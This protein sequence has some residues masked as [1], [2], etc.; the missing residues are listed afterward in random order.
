MDDSLSTIHV[1]RDRGINNLILSAILLRIATTRF[2]LHKIAK[3]TLLNI[4]QKRLNVNIKQIVDE[5][6]SEFIKASVMKIKE[7]EKNFNKFKP[8]ISVVFPSQDISSNDTI[9]EIKG[10]RILELTNET[11]LELCN[12][13]RAAMK[14]RNNFITNSYYLVVYS[15]LCMFLFKACINMQCAYTL[16]QDLKK[17]QEHL[18]LIDYLHLLYLVTPYDLISQIKLTGSIYYDVVISNLQFLL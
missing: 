12:L 4:Q 14:G 15:F 17:A 9:K 10:K 1:E 11:E 3:K 18:I 16:Y 7:K 13:G 8:N 6:L 2:E 5:T